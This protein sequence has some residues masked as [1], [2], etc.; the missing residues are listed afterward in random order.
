PEG[1]PLP[2]E[3]LFECR[4]LDAAV[5]DGDAHPGAGRP[6]VA[7]QPVGMQQR[8]ELIEHVGHWKKPDTR[9]ETRETRSD[10]FFSRVSC[11]VS[12]V[13]CLVTNR[14]WRPTSG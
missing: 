13:S 1:D 11:L 8:Q 6:R 5:D 2:R 4:A 12:R 10:R 3:L 7:E 9:H 14:R